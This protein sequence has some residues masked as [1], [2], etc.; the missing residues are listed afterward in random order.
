VL[1]FWDV[2]R[3]GPLRQGSAERDECEELQALCS[4]SV[5][6]AGL[7]LG[8]RLNALG[9]GADRPGGH[10]LRLQRSCVLLARAGTT[11]L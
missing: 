9:Q 10:L 7:G 3:R 5:A 1:L 8:L 11:P 6:R 2:F 4:G